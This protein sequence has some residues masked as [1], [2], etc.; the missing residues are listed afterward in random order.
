MNAVR[1]LDFIDDIGMLDWQ[2]LATAEEFGVIR[3]NRVET[4]ILYIIN[5]THIP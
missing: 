2:Q 1:K 4:S 3:L 5:E